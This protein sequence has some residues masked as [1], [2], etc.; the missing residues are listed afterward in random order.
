MVNLHYAGRTRSHIRR[1]FDG[2]PVSRVGVLPST[3]PGVPTAGWRARRRD[4]KHHFVPVIDYRNNNVE[5]MAYAE[6]NGNYSSQKFLR[7]RNFRDKRR[8]SPP[9]RALTVPRDRRDAVMGSSP[10]RARV[11]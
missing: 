4:P 11:I 9:G 6:E 3:G 1:R 5:H 8:G 10:G 2:Q 7:S